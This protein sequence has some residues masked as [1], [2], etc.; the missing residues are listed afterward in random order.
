V[1]LAH[2]G[3]AEEDDVLLA[4]DEAQ[5]V[6]AI[7]LLAADARL[8][9]EVEVGELLDGREVSDGSRPKI[10]TTARSRLYKAVSTHV[11]A[12]TKPSK[13]AIVRARDGRY[14]TS[15]CQQNFLELRR[16]VAP[17][18]NQRRL[19][20]IGQEGL[21]TRLAKT[22]FC[23]RSSSFLTLRVAVVC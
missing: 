6:Q 12:L 15:S 22:Y 20:S 10:R 2:A 1:A 13:C 5:F 16:L 17:A 14:R 11:R 19:I 3:R 9:A 23:K 18:S 4:L 7:D 8:E 21:W